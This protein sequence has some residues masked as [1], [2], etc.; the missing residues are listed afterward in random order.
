MKK[1]FV[2]LVMVLGMALSAC[3]NAETEKK[4]GGMSGE[5][6]A[7][8]SSVMEDSKA[9]DESS[10]A[11]DSVAP[12]QSDANSEEQGNLGD[13]F[14]GEYVSE[15]DGST[16]EIAPNGDEPKDYVVQVD[17]FRLTLLDDGVGLA[18][19]EGMSFTA[20]DANGEP[21]S[22]MITLEGEIAT[23]TFTDSNWPLLENGTSFT[24]KKTSDIPYLIQE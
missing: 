3:G 20:T 19:A 9:S 5:P 23:V 17:L 22:G 14:V 21:I 12:A 15:E 8:E 18:T 13:I 4:D 11:E 10:V 6:I 2:V 1:K 16:L 24:F 7:T